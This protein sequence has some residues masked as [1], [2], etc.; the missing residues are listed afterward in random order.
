M[1]AVNRN[2]MNSYSTDDESSEASVA[3]NLNPR[4]GYQ[5]WTLQTL[6][7]QQTQLKGETQNSAGGWSLVS[8]THGHEAAVRKSPR[9]PSLTRL[10]CLLKKPNPNCRSMSES[11]PNTGFPRR[12]TFAEALHDAPDQNRCLK[13]LSPPPPLSSSTHPA[14][15]R[16][17]LSASI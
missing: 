1:A 8:R 14:L 3:R 17:F 4:R 16:A 13:R 11:L 6:C 15:S 2:K 9:P 7:G 10:T 5:S 12:Q